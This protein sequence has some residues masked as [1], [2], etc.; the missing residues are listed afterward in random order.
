MLSPDEEVYYMS[1][2]KAKNPAA[3]YIDLED[4]TCEV[5]HKEFIS[6]QACLVHMKIHHRSGE[7]G[8]HD[9]LDTSSFLHPGPVMESTS[10]LQH[11]ASPGER[12]ICNYCGKVF[13][14]K[15]LLKQ[16]VR[17]EHQKHRFR[18]PLCSTEFNWQSGLARHMKKCRAQLASSLQNQEQQGMLASSLHQE[19]H[20]QL[21]SSSNIQEQEQ[22]QPDN[23][24]Q[25]PP[26]A[27]T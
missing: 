1:Q 24:N 3:P 7:D 21:A 12:C 27:T 15:Q 20:A 13:K 10:Y 6:P 23:E 17:V 25:Q 19:Q 22:Q 18:C 14:F 4:K 11:G 16:H 5:C 9:D 2:T 8:N 26:L